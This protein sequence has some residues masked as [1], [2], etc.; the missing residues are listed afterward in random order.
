MSPCP[1]LLGHRGASKYADENTPAAFEL[2]LAHGCDGFEFD[3]RYSAD[4]RGVI[5]HDPRYKRKRID[6]CSFPELGLPSADDVVRRYAGRAYIDIELKVSGEVQPV[7]DA[8][9]DTESSRFVISSFLPEVLEETNARRPEVPL[10]LICENS[11]QL[12]KWPRLP[13]RAVMVHYLMASGKL[14][15]DLHTAGKQVFVWTV[16]RP[17]TMRRLAALGV[18]GIISDDTRL[19]VR[20]LKKN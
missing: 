1:L 5:C 16:N 17:I 14:V 11:R 4:A 7:L 18:D 6:A 10:G 12:R 20:T 9:G 19:L 13:V 15:E 2:A 8:L 3:V